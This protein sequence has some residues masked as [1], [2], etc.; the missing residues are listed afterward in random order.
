MR[1]LLALVLVSALLL[2]A[3]PAFALELL[4]GGDTYPIKTDKAVSWYAETALIPHEKFVDASQSPFHIGLSEL[5]GV[6][7]NWSFPPAGTAG[8][9]FTNTL[10]A[11]PA[12]LPN[13]MYG[14]FMNDSSLYLED[15]MIWDIT[16]YIQEY[17]PAYYAFLQSNPAYDRA[18]KTD[19]GQ[20]YGFGFFREAGGWNDTYLG[21][22]VRTDWL[23]ECGLEIP[24]T[25]SEFENVIRVFKEKYGAKLSFSNT[26]VLNTGLSGAFGAYSQETAQYFVKDGKVG[27]A[28]AEPEWRAY[29]T[30]LNKLWDADLLDQDF[31]SLDDTSIKGKIHNDKAGISITSM[32]QLNNWNKER[33][34]NGQEPVWVGIPYP[35]GDDGT[36][37]MVFGGPGIGNFVSVV[38]KSADEE[39]MKL[40]LQLLN[41]AYTDAGFYYWNFGKEG[42]SWVKGADGT[43]ELTPLVTEDKDTDPLVKYGG[44]TWS[45]SGIQATKLLYLKN[46]PVAIQANDT[47]FYPNEAVTSAWKWPVGATFTVE[48]ADELKLIST[49]LNTYA[50]E[51]FAKFITGSKDIEK[52][53]DWTEHL[54]NLDSYS[55]KRVLEIRQACYDRYLAR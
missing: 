9:V 1:K 5:T 45:C 26:R 48:E 20:Y 52:D 6:K 43:P 24:K 18:M 49:S 14:A 42:V 4:S 30:W 22:V 46:S 35:K 29:L 19:K 7:I 17:A 13:I 27:F 21:P 31:L 25:I 12:N 55:L 10:L 54:K 3:V 53:A 16:P 11:D 2:S 37:S 38:T 51:A 44:A 41:Y 36:L 32:G 8:N 34:A 50:A 39:T 23:K 15:E 33:Q 28:H 40:C 47:W